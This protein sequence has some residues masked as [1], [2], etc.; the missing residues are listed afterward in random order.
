M[1]NSELF[2]SCVITV[3]YVRLQTCLEIQW[4]LLH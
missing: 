4:K 2:I 3:N 1:T